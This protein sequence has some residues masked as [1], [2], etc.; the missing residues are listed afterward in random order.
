MRPL[1]QH[2]RVGASD[3][4][5]DSLVWPPANEAADILWLEPNE[6]ALSASSTA[7]TPPPLAMAAPVSAPIHPPNAAPVV[8][9]SLVREAAGSLSLAQ[10]LATGVSME[11]HDAVAVVSQLA[12][13]LAVDGRSPSAG[14]LPALNAIRLDSDGLLHVRL[15]RIGSESLTAGFGRV[16]QALLHDKP[17]PAKLRLLAWRAT[18][19]AGAS[20]TLSEIIGELQRWERPGRID[21]LKDLYERASIAGPPPSAIFETVDLDPPV[22]NQAPPRV[23]ASERKITAPTPRQVVLVVA[24]AIV[25]VTIG[26]VAAWLVARPGDVV[27]PV[28]VKHVTAAPAPAPAVDPPVRGRTAA[29][30]PRNAARPP[31][32]AAPARAAAAGTTPVPNPVPNP[33]QMGPPGSTSTAAPPSPARRATVD[34]SLSTPAPTASLSAVVP[35]PQSMASSATDLRLYK[36]DVQLYTS[37]DVGVTEPV[38]VKPY[39]PLR[40]HPP[41]PDTQLGVLELVVDARGLVESVHLKSPANRYREKWWLF[42]AKDWQFE[43][44][45]KN[46]MPVRFL[47]RILLTDLNIAEPQ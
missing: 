16:L 11:W 47:K 32:Q 1:D 21:K 44:A 6:P 26:S 46:G 23:Q 31:A 30:S 4:S 25:C 14:A 45:K 19:D 41:I 27:A 28:P 7:V 15:D 22:G 17:T 34:G 8:G 43:P 38:L 42:T 35:A 13:Q 5:D 10:L 20:L 33:V 37:G 36:P 18:S 9:P 29:R 39:L 24:G 12:N 3:S 40:A 2:A